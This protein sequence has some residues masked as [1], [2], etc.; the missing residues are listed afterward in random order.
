M[1]IY[2][3]NC[4]HTKPPQN[5]VNN[6]YVTGNGE[7]T[8]SILTNAWLI[9]N[10]IIKSLIFIYIKPRIP[11]LVFIIIMVKFKRKF[12]TLHELMIFIK[13][14]MVSLFRALPGCVFPEIQ[15]K[16][17]INKNFFFSSENI[18]KVF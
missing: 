7:E 1:F 13:L 12:Y 15:K 5:C 9:S 3:P 4:K 2:V 10:K 14:K 18:F 17:I 11:F 6:Y 16:N 8:M